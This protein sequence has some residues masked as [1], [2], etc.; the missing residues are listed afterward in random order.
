[1]ISIQSL[2][3]QHDPF[4]AKATDDSGKAVI[5]NASSS[6]SQYMSPRQL[7]ESSLA[8]CLYITAIRVLQ[9]HNLTIDHLEVSVE[10]NSMETETQFLIHIILDQSICKKLKEEVL[11]EIYERSYVKNVLQKPMIFK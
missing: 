4:L 11:T 6:V 2:A 9:D 3:T 10:L 8:G 5:F 7:L 1:M